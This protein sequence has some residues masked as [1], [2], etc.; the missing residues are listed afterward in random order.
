L[1]FAAA[2]ALGNPPA[3]GQ[4][5]DLLGRQQIAQEQGNVAGIAQGCEHRQQVRRQLR[6]AAHANG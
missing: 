4:R 2:Q 3:L 1:G 6:L 5:L